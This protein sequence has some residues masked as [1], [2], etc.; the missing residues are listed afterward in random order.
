M[1]LTPH[2]QS[3]P[4]PQVDAGMAR[5]TADQAAQLATT[6]TT[7][8]VEDTY[9][10]SVRLHQAETAARLACHLRTYAALAEA[11]DHLEEP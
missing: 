3:E 8:A 9:Q 4:T 5:W 6:L 2:P 11:D 10:R 7:Q 1:T